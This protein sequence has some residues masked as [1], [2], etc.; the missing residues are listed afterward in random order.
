[1][2]QRRRYDKTGTP[3]LTERQVYWLEHLR[4]CEASGLTVSA[5]AKKHRLSIHALYQSRK[6]YRRREAFASSPKRS[7]VTFARVEAV[8]SAARERNLP[9]CQQMQPRHLAAA[10]HSHSH[11]HHGAIVDVSPIAR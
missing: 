1:M 2:G 9:T 7:S 8:S 4:A 5:Y 11:S 6:V 3:Q 10:P